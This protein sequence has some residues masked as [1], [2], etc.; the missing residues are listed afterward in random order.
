[1]TT[2]EKNKGKLI[3]VAVKNSRQAVGSYF[4]L[5]QIGPHEFLWMDE[6]ADGSEVATDISAD[7]CEEAIRLANQKLKMAGF[8]MLNCGFRYT[9]PER[10]EH[11][12]NALF[13]QMIASY[14]SSNGT[15]FDGDLGNNCFIN[16]AS[17][18]ARDL[19]KRL[20]REE[21]LL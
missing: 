20:Q 12:I 7:S 19:W 8:R 18:E 13:H 11:G 1:M 4:F 10:D 15:Y 9:L 21:K 2:T 5:R 6:Q 16:F 14:S 17:R 3:H